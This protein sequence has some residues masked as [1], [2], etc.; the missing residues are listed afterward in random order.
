MGKT[1]TLEIVTP[2]RRFYNDETEMVILKTSE[3]EMGVLYD[4]E[5]F[6]APLAI[7]AIRIKEGNAFRWAATSGGFLT[8]RPEKTTLLVD[9]AEWIGEI[10]LERAERAKERAEERLREG[11]EKGVDVMRADAA[12]KRAINR[13]RLGKAHR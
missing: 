9:S 10:D 11:K 1:F 7:G 8:V 5:P 13:I 3:G 4:H 6:V 12:L 2:D